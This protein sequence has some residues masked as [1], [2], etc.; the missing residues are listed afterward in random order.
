MF[1][2]ADRQLLAPSQVASLVLSQMQGEAHNSS[3]T[4]PVGH[5]AFIMAKHNRNKIIDIFI[6]NNLIN[7]IYYRY[8]NNFIILC[9]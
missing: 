5:S 3:D 6:L 2:R 1:L 4:S 8:L 7:Y 9:N